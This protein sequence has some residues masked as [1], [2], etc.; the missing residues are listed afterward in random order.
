MASKLIKGIILIFLLT[1][2]LAVGCGGDGGSTA[3][4]KTID[5]L[6]SM[7][8]INIPSGSLKS[9][10]FDGIDRRVRVG[11]ILRHCIKFPNQNILQF[12][13]PK[14][15]ED[16]LFTCAVSFKSDIERIPAGSFIFSFVDSLG[17]E[18]PLK[19]EFIDAG[20]MEDWL[21]VD[22]DLSEYSGREGTL[23]IVSSPQ[24]EILK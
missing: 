11:K 2:T 8:M 17:I 15:P 4:L 6:M 22:I 18:T 21:E 20:I 14:L 24:T 9:N 1:G 5:Y 23:K 7:D 16:A 19:S 3:V 12:E 13:L 10:P